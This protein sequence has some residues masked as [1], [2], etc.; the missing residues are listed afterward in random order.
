MSPTVPTAITTCVLARRGP[1]VRS[2]FYK[3]LG[4]M[5]TLSGDQLPLLDIMPFTACVRG[6]AQLSDDKCAVQASEC[7]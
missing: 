2:C 5:K 4:L 1:S 7:A 6:A 3:S